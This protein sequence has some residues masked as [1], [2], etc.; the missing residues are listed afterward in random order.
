MARA[1]SAATK[2]RE[3]SGG[4]I[5][6]LRNRALTFVPDRWI[7]SSPVLGLVL[8]VAMPSVRLQ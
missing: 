1:N 8:L 5:S 2:G 4:G 3:N 6:P 7:R